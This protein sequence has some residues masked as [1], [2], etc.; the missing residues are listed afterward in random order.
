MIGE[1]RTTGAALNPVRTEHEVVDEQLAAT[2]EEIGERFFAV[3]TV[4]YVF[5]LN[6]FPGK[7]AALFA[8][9][10]AEF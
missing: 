10:V 1:Q 5:L 3:R 9:F 8:E 4:E 2:G 7:F 6:F